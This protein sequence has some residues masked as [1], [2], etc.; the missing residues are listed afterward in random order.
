MAEFR[1]IITGIL[2]F[3]TIVG[4]GIIT[5]MVDN[6]A[7]GITTYSL[8]G[9]YFGYRLL[10]TMIPVMILLIVVQEMCS[11]LGVVTGKGLSD[12]LRENFPLKVTFIVIILLLIV[13]ITN[14]ISEFAGIA[15]ASEIFGV[16]RYISL[17]ISGFLVWWI[18][19]K[20]N[21]QSVE[22]IFLVACVFYV[23]YIIAGVFAKPDW[24]IVMH[25]TFTPHFIWNKE[26]LIMIIGIVGTTIAPWMQFYLQSSVAEKHIKKEDY[27]Y[28]K[29]DVIIGSIVAIIV[30]FFI[31]VT[32]AATIN[33]AGIRIETAADAAKSL[34]PLAGNYAAMLFAFGL[35][36]A[37]LFAAS[38]LP[39]STAYTVAE[40]F[41]W[42]SGVNRKYHEAKQFYT[43]YT[44]MIILG[45]IPVL[46]PGFSLITLMYFSQVLNGILLPVIII[47]MLKLINKK[48]LMG[49]YVNSKAYN[50][51]SWAAAILIIVLTLG[52]AV[53]VFL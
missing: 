46:F 50:I 18:V 36:N 51:F 38:I 34:I 17:P 26:Y 15:A 37:S 40:A 42:E 6:D 21:Y 53:T 22:K 45:I 43:L 9:S 47:V 49:E 7:G 20:G 33:Q 1:K 31:T 19:L 14:T 5:A 41:G 27:F 13:N 32:T 30:V 25:E 3:L 44:I 35:L 29:M 24:N 39:L 23:A 11:R 52:T 16:S 12:L 8:A 28:S 48:E 10:W 4:P 2:L